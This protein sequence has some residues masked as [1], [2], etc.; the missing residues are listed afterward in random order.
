MRLHY[1]VEETLLYHRLDSLPTTRTRNA[2]Q[3]PGK[4]R[5]LA[6][7]SKSAGYVFR[8]RVGVAPDRLP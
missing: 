3:A 7:L 1:C 6:K 2:K 5:R 8:V 4:L